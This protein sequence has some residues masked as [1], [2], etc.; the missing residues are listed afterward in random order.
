[1]T[2]KAN[3]STAVAA[4]QPAGT[5]GTVADTAT[6]TVKESPASQPALPGSVEVADGVSFS[7]I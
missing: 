5:P 7:K 6:L 2:S 3:D 1:M 4:G